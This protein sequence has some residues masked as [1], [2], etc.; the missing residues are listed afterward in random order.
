MGH[1][2]GGRVNITE[3]AERIRR[4]TGEEA[5]ALV[6]SL[7]RLDAKAAEAAAERKRALAQMDERFL[8]CKCGCPVR[9]ARRLVWEESGVQ[10]KAARS[11]GQLIGGYFIDQEPYFMPD[12]TR[13]G[14]EDIDGMVSGLVMYSCGLADCDA[15]TR[16]TSETYIGWED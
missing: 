14:H 6:D 8:K 2:S 9:T 5:I 12:G 3:L 10:L 16:G 1:A 4:L 13:V 11:N 15:W 7:A